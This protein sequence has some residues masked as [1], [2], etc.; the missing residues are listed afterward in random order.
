MNQ[1]VSFQITR[2]SRSI[3]AQTAGER[4]LSRVFTFVE[5]EVS[6][7]RRRVAALIAL[8]RLVTGMSPHVAPH[9]FNRAA[10]VLT[11]VTAEGAFSGVSK[12]VSLQMTGCAS[13]IL[14]LTA[15]ERSLPA[16]S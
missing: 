11:E 3:V 5:G 14:T 2:V 16:V 8:V 9:L 6:A 10:L 1:H 12:G 4:F 15:R 13:S 7:L